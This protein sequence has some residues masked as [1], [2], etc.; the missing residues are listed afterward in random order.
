MRAEISRMKD[1]GLAL[2]AEFN[3]LLAEHHL[4]EADVT[5]QYQCLGLPGHGLC[6]RPHVRLPEKPPAAHGL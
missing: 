2:K 1:R 5:P 4:T 6:G 3:Q